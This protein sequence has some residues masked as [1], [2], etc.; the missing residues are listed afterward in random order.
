[1]KDGGGTM[2][3]KALNSITSKIRAKYGKMLTFSD[4]KQLSGLSSVSEIASYLRTRTKYYEALSGAN[5]SAIHRDHLEDMLK[6]YRI[7]E[8]ASICRFERSVGDEMFRFTVRREEADALLQFIRLLYANNTESYIPKLSYTLDKYSNIDFVGLCNVKDVSGMRN[9]LSATDFRTA[10]LLMS[11]DSPA[12]FD[13]IE[14]AFERVVYETA[15]K[16]IATYSDES[17]RQSLKNMLILTAELSDCS[18]IIRGKRYYGAAPDDIGPDLLGYTYLIPQKTFKKMLIAENADTAEEIFKNTGYSR[19]IERFG[20]ADPDEL[21][22]MILHSLA[23]HNIHFSSS[24]P[25]VMMSYFAELD[26][27][28]ANLIRIIEGVRYK[29]SPEQIL[30]NIIARTE[31]N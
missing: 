17:A 22:L 31:G 21:K 25:V 27:E 24:P 3:D 8:T 30:G 4:Y 18:V 29:V 19:Y 9:F 16:S 7:S 15:F 1:M 2:Q 12:D 28:T 11:D 5:D 20:T 10:A 6:K 14:T 23:S 13:I 26:I